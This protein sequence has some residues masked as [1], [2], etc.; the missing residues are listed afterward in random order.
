MK[1]SGMPVVAMSMAGS[2]FLLGGCSPSETA[3]PPSQVA[4]PAP[5]QASPTLG[6]VSGQLAGAA[7]GSIATLSPEVPQPLPPPAWTVAMDQVQL[8]FSPE[9]LIGRVGFPVSFRSSDPE[10]HNINVRKVDKRQSEFNRSIPP[11]TSF[12]YVFSEPGFYDVRCDIHPAM[13]ATIFVAAS[14]FAES[15][16]STGAFAFVNVPPGPYTLTVYNGAATMEKQIEVVQG[17]N[18]IGLDGA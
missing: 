16:D 15:L 7:P 18:K 4:S 11:G 9:L 13:N 10:L 1:V 8:Q 6:T 12:D 14:P 3:A 5:P 17:E 2:L